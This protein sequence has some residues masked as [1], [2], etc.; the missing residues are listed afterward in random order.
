M[1]HRARMMLVVLL[2][3]ALALSCT[4]LQQSGTPG[5]GGELTVEALPSSDSV[6]LEWGRLVTVTN[7][8]AV[9]GATLLW[10]QDEAGTVRVVGYNH[11]TQQLWSYARVIARN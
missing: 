2:P 9:E 11:F 6:P 10:Y 7:A 3:A 5:E 1:S 8:P 4:S